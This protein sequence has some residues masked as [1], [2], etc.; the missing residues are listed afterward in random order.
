MPGEIA[1]LNVY[2]DNSSSK[3][4]MALNITHKTSKTMKAHK[5][6]FK[7]YVYDNTK[8][9]FFIAEARETKEMVVQFKIGH[10]KE[11]TSRLKKNLGRMLLKKFL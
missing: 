9:K 11:D 3:Y 6:C 10:K 1:Y 5:Q 7:N 2:V 8:E 4:P